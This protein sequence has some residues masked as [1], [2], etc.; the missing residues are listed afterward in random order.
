MNLSTAALFLLLGVLT[1]ASPQRQAIG[2]QA[3]YY[4]LGE[5]N[6]GEL[7]STIG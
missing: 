5:A 2:N 6:E 4:P 3:A 1:A 7:S